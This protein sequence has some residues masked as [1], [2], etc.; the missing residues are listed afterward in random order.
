VAVIGGGDDRSDGDVPAIL[1]QLAARG[2]MAMMTAAL[3]AAVADDGVIGD[4][5]TKS[6]QLWVSCRL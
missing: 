3:S 2:R 5:A 1:L 4:A 6:P